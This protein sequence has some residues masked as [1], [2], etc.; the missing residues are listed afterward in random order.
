MLPFFHKALVISNSLCKKKKKKEIVSDIS[1]V[2]IGDYAS[3]NSPANSLFSCEVSD[4]ALTR[5]P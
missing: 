2:K 1:D 4:Y 5:D 3:T